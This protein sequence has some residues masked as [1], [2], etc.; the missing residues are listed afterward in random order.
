MSDKIL[1]M[2]GLM[3][4]AN[5]IQIGFGLFVIKPFE[6]RHDERSFLNPARR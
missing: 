5:A 3:R 6:L 1:N 2:L 4:R